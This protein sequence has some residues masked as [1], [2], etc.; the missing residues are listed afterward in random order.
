MKEQKEVPTTTTL[1]KSCPTRQSTNI[2][3]E[4]SSR[5]AFLKAAQSGDVPQ[6]TTL[7]QAEPSLIDARSTSKGYTALHYAAMGGSLEAVELLASRGIAA[8]V[9]SS[10]GS[11]ASV[12]PLQVALEYKRLPV[13][14]RLQQLRDAHRNNKPQS[15]PPANNDAAPERPAPRH[16]PWILASASDG[17]YDV[18]EIVGDSAEAEAEASRLVSASR[19]FVWRKAALCPEALP[20]ALH[21]LLHGSGSSPLSKQV[22]DTNVC[23]RED[24]RFMY[25][26]PDR[27]AKGV[28]SP[29]PVVKVTAHAPSSPHTLTLSTR[30]TTYPLLSSGVLPDE[31][32]RANAFSRDARA[33]EEICAARR[34]GPTAAAAR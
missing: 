18:P 32:E 10:G 31:A 16:P 27:L 22:L 19:S 6:L 26:S 14:R 13:A 34:D 28:Y 9:A 5:A 20:A 2:M 21:A 3:P 11:D 24:R 15:P 29:E 33:A 12:T 30:L 4:Q 8:D 25:F 17:G 1:V 7:L 23:R